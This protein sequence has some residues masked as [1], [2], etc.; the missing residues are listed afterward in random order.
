MYSRYSKGCPKNFLGTSRVNLPETSLRDQI[1]TSPGR[2][3]ETSPGRHWD[4]TSPGWSN[5]IFRG[6]PGDI[7]GGSPL[8]V[9]G[10]N[11]SWLG[12]SM[13]TFQLK[14]CYMILTNKLQKYQH[15]HEVK[16]IKMNTWQ[17]K[18]YYHLIKVER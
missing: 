10:T 5:M 4:G 2:Y 11:I 15:Y 8:D 12:S 3:F 1:R 13:I 6:R 17:L 18:K 16:L 14:N 9:L 7:G